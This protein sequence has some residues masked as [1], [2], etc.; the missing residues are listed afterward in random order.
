MNIE[1]YMPHILFFFPLYINGNAVR[2]PLTVGFSYPTNSY[3]P[4]DQSRC[5]LHCLGQ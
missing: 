3:S 2:F 5:T 1:Q 4:D